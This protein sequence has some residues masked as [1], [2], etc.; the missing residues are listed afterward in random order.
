MVL[1]SVEEGFYQPGGAKKAYWR[2]CRLSRA[3]HSAFCP[4]PPLSRSIHLLPWAM[5][6]G[7]RNFIPV[8]S[9]RAVAVLSSVLNVYLKVGFF[10]GWGDVCIILLRI[11]L[12]LQ[13]SESIGK[14]AKHD[15]HEQAKD[16]VQAL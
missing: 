15:Q 9:S 12:I 5:A 16:G 1:G 11:T 14:V 4:S 7:G 10:G 6:L 8:T 13:S 3:L 2:C